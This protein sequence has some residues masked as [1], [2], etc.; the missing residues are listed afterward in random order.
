LIFCNSLVQLLCFYQKD[1]LS[2][3]QTLLQVDKTLYFERFLNVRTPV[4]PQF[5]NYARGRECVRPWKKIRPRAKAAGAREKIRRTQGLVLEDFRVSFQNP[6]L[7]RE[8]IDSGSFVV[9]F[10]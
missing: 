6:P 1:N 2:K 4:R 5:K 8:N 10:S 9:I 3:I 7:K